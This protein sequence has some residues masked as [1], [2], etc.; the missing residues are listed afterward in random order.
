MDFSVPQN[1]ARLVS[2]HPQELWLVDGASHVDMYHVSL[3]EYKDRVVG[4]LDK[5]MHW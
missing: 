4:V 1:C 2:R 3:L 5:Y